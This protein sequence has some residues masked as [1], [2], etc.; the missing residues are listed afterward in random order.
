MA[1]FAAIVVHQLFTLW[2]PCGVSAFW[3]CFCSARTTF[4]KSGSQHFS[5]ELRCPDR[6][7]NRFWVT[8]SCIKPPFSVGV[9]AIRE[10]PYNLGTENLGP[11]WP[12]ASSA[13]LPDGAFFRL[14]LDFFVLFPQQDRGLLLKLGGLFAGQRLDTFRRSA[15]RMALSVSCLCHA[16]TLGAQRKPLLFS[17]ARCPRQAC[18]QRTPASGCP[19]GSFPHDPH[20]T[21]SRKIP[22]VPVWL[23]DTGRTRRISALLLVSW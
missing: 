17:S 14:R 5:C 16:P 8:S 2:R 11:M 21:P 20:R 18:R 15:A 4:A 9:P 1:L 3:W 12:E 23:F 7:G 6:K 22:A 10:A 19:P 13:S